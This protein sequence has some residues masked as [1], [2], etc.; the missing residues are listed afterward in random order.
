MTA[1]L[2]VENPLF[3]WSSSSLLLSSGLGRALLLVVIIDSLILSCYMF[4]LVKTRELKRF[5]VVL[6]DLS[7]SDS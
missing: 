4:G 7:R 3:S 1:A 6:A 5:L 2:L